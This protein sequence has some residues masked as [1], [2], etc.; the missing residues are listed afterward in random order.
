M[1]CSLSDCCSLCSTM[2]SGFAMLSCCTNGND[3]FLFQPPAHCGGLATA[4]P[5]IQNNTTWLAEPSHP[6]VHIKGRRLCPSP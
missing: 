3:G 5:V 1:C 2:V 6:Q 4:T